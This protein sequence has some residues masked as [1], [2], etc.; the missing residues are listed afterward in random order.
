MAEENTPGYPPVFSSISTKNVPAASTNEND[1][2]AAL[3]RETQLHRIQGLETGIIIGI[4]VFSIVIVILIAMLIFLL[5]TSNQG[6]WGKTAVVGAYNSSSGIA[7]NPSLNTETLNTSPM[8]TI[9]ESSSQPFDE[10]LFLSL[11]VTKNNN[12]EEESLTP[13][14]HAKKKFPN[15]PYPHKQQQ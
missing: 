8:P 4:V 12:T 9:L 7:L 3:L 11:S 10:N 1:E 13:S 15:T 2:Y 6:V 5:V 14:M